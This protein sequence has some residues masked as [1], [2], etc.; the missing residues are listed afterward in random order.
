MYDGETAPVILLPNAGEKWVTLAP[1]GPASWEFTSLL[2][3]ILKVCPVWVSPYV[4]RV[5]TSSQELTPPTTS[6]SGLGLFSVH[7]SVTGDHSPPPPWSSVS[8]ECPL[9][10][11]DASTLHFHYINTGKAHRHE[12]LGMVSEW[13]ASLSIDAEVRQGQPLPH[14]HVLWAQALMFCELKKVLQASGVSSNW[15]FSTWAEHGRW[16]QSA[17]VLQAGILAEIIW[18]MPGQDCA[19][20]NQGAPRTRSFNPPRWLPLPV[21]YVSIYFIIYNLRALV[22]DRCGLESLPHCSLS[23]WFWSNMLYPSEPRCPQM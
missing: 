18:R 19:E 22:A 3:W 8:C 23:I 16:R 14:S 4:N 15:L 11:L 5:N 10:E 6:P 12:L 2:P 13:T 20:K 7:P 9:L 1:G 21:N 17:W